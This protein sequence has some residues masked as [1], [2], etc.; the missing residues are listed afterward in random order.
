MFRK[1]F[2]EG[3]DLRTGLDAGIQYFK[4][5]L[6]MQASWILDQGSFVHMAFGNNSGECFHFQDAIAV[7]CS[8]IFRQNTLALG[9]R[10]F[11]PVQGS[12]YRRY[13]GDTV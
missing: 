13:F 1:V 10:H 5:I 3:N 12:Q 4:E 2:A 8:I 7:L 11:H 9:F 6:A